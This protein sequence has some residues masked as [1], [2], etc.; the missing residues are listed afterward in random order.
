MLS[1]QNARGVFDLR[2]P[3]FATWIERAR[4][5]APPSRAA[6][7]VAS[8][9]IARQGADAIGRPHAVPGTR[10]VTV[11]SVTAAVAAAAVAPLVL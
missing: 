4:V 10:R 8:I 7:G 6:A 9:P 11:A 3:P 5:V 1:G 2:N